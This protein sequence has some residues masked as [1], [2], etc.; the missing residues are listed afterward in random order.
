MKKILL[1]MVSSVIFISGCAS[2]V[3][4]DKP[5]RMLIQDGN[6]Y[7]QKRNYK[8]AAIAFE[9]AVLNSDSPNEARQAQRLLADA[10]FNNRDWAGAI[11]SYESY[12]DLYQR[13]TE[14]PYVLFRLGL[15]YSKISRHARADQASTQKSVNF[16]TMLKNMYPTRFE[17]FG[18]GTYLD[19]MNWKLAEHE[20]QVAAFYMR[21]KQ[22]ESVVYR[23]LYLLNNYPDSH[24]IED[25]YVMLTR[26]SLQIPG[27]E[28]VSMLYLQELEEE[29]PEN[30]QL[31]KLRRQVEFKLKLDNE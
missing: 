8:N 23:L 6:A 22:P 27:R 17:E 19:A 18:A 30:D 4:T 16:F 14:T 24:R 9:A 13:D 15:A 12:N 11:A 28:D 20:Y 5:S 7:M 29:Y 10:R 31:E 21:I 26:A 25:A 3:D 2:R 1:L